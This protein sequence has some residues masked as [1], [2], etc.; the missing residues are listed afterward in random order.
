MM[1]GCKGLTAKGCTAWSLDEDIMFL[2]REKFCDKKINT[3]LR[4]N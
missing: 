3:D 2:K 4:F 1:L